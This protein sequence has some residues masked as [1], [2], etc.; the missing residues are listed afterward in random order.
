MGHNGKLGGQNAQNG[1]PGKSCT[2]CVSICLSDC[3][4]VCPFTHQGSYSLWT[5]LHLTV[6]LKWLSLQSCVCLP[7]GSKKT[8]PKPMIDNPNASATKTSHLIR[9]RPLKMPDSDTVQ[10]PGRT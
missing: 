8:E 5:S 7:Q 4:S 3:T 10:P 9:P 1:G 6:S 2:V